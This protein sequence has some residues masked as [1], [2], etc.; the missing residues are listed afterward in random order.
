M[1]VHAPGH[2]GIVDPDGS[3][4]FMWKENPAKRE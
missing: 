1:I 3:S 4:R 2:P